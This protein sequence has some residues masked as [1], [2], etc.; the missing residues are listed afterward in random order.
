M[1]DNH[2]DYRRVIIIDCAGEQVTKLNWQFRHPLNA[3]DAD[4]G[5]L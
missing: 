5:K 2:N 4:L 1:R 3:R